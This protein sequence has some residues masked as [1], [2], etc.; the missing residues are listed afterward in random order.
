[1]NINQSITSA[2]LLLAPLALQ[3]GPYAPAAG[4]PG[5]TAI[6]RDSASLIEWATTVSNYTAGTDVSS[7]WQ[8]TANALGYADNSIIS[9][10]NGG[11]LTLSF[12]KAITNG[13]GFDFAV[14]ENGFS[15]T[16]L[17]L[18]YVEVSSDGVINQ[19]S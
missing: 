6:A 9:L 11:S 16:F 15:D 12:D 14:F 4:K 7:T 17:E 8:V 5:S 10:G 13:S 19:Q 18:A 1:M 3:A 2:L